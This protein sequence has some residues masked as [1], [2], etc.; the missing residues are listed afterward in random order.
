[1]NQ[2]DCSQNHDF[3]V[4]GIQDES[5]A[6]GRWMVPLILD[7]REKANRS[8]HT[9]LN[10]QRLQNIM[11]MENI[12]EHCEYGTVLSDMLRDDRLVCGIRNKAYRD[13]YY[14]KWH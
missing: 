13:D 3:T 11:S 9:W 2:S 8:L 14:K 12:A 6:C 4:R 10:C 5:I 1:M 7:V